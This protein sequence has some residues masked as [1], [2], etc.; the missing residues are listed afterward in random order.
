M[1]PRLKK[2][3]LYHL[4]SEELG[5]NP[6]ETSDKRLS[7]SSAGSNICRDDAA[8]ICRVRKF[9]LLTMSNI[10]VNPAHHTYMLQEC[11]GVIR[12]LPVLYVCGKYLSH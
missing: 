4:T 2:M 6:I 10:S 11:D 12:A 7:A 9:A 5:G 1:L 3:A 8:V